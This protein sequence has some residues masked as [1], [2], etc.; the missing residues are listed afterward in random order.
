MSS[1]QDIGIALREG[2]ERVEKKIDELPKQITD[3]LPKITSMCEFTEMYSDVAELTKRFA[4]IPGLRYSDQAGFDVGAGRSECTPST[5][6][7]ILSAVKKWALR[8]ASNAGGA[9]SDIYHFPN[10]R[11]VLWI[12]GLAGSG[13]STIAQSMA[14]W[15]DKQGLLGASFFCARFGDRNNVQLIFP[16]IAHQLASKHP[17]FCEAATK[18]VRENPDIHNSLPYRQLEKLLVDPLK[19]LQSSGTPLPE[20]IIVIDAL[21][22]CKDDETISVIL[23][24]LSHHVE[25]LPSLRFIVTSRPEENISLG[26]HS[27]VLLRHTHNFRLSKIPS[28]AVDEDIRTYLQV[29]FAEIAKLHDLEHSWPGEEKLAL[30]VAK[31]ARLFIFAA[32][33]VKHV[34]DKL[35]D[36]PRERLHNLLS[37]T[38]TTQTGS[39]ETPYVHLDRLYIQVLETAY[40]PNIDAQ[41]ASELKLIM[42][43]LV[44][45]QD[46]LSSVSLDVF[47][48]L[49]NSTTRNRLRR[50]RSIFV[51]PETSHEFIGTIH[52]S[53]SDFLLDPLRCTLSHFRIS[54]NYQHAFL[55][56]HC[57]QTMN[58]LLRRDICRTEDCTLNADVPDLAA[59][60]TKHVP[61]HL[62]YACTSW[63]EH[64]RQSLINSDLL[65]ILEEFL[66][67]HL[68]HWL[69][70]MSVIGAVDLRICKN[71]EDVRR[72]LKVSRYLHDF[73]L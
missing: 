69:E 41:L 49:R 12:N 10:D 8:D 56:I 31:A 59:R 38:G 62:L 58:E 51:V 42:G 18:A 6:K 64:T 73:V 24:A 19:S 20:Y 67:K 46:Q 61:P 13:K 21:D 52:P 45:L 27:D 65:S 66:R 40:G 44:V 35:F 32:T 71:L 14:S 4:V 34:A 37:D 2:F 72:T 25:S 5:R 1:D 47:L 39:G 33:T 30:L 68:L 54:P 63:T 36:N 11:R 57:I 28:E 17:G 3:A 23:T 26:F 22:E 48:H 9:T 70:V 53:F 15:C 50:L 16:T 29:Q 55:S 43:T 7:E 60:I